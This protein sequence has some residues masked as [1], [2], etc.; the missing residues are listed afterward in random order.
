VRAL[1]LEED[2]MVRQFAL[3]SPLAL[4]VVSAACGSE[5][6]TA[7][8]ED[9]AA[10]DQTEGAGTDTAE[11]EDVGTT[12]SEL[13]GGGFRGGGVAMRG[14]AVG[15]RGG[16][17]GY[18]GG[19]VG[20]RGGAVGYR[21]GA[22]GYRG[23]VYGGRVGGVYGGRYGYGWGHAAAIHRGWVNGVW[24]PGWGWANGA[25]VVSG[26]A[27]YS[28]VATAD[29]DAILGPGIAVC[30]YFADVGAGHCVGGSW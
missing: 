30:D 18:R 23:G 13:R 26:G 22:V 10:V 25:W 8:D 5:P 1:V 16:A 19:A 4:V 24:A 21:G 15:V 29:C 2:A 12:E 14:G 17:V 27:Q 9:V 7:T 3:L 20:Y 11:S 6:P 28:C